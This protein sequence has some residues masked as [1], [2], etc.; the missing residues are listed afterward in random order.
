MSALGRIAIWFIVVTVFVVAA[1]GLLGLWGYRSIQSGGASPSPLTYDTHTELANISVPSK[2][3]ALAWST[4]GSYLAA[5]TTYSD[6]SEIFIMD[7]AKASVTH[8]LKVTGYDL[9]GTEVVASSFS[10]ASGPAESAGEA[11]GYSLALASK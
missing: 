10:D 1:F 4:D 8:T 3:F 5:S 2:P 7:V 9:G 11:L 6:P